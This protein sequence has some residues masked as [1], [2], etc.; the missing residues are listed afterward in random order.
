MHMYEG[1]VE[2]PY[3]GTM[4]C[5]PCR[6]SRQVNWG[7]PSPVRKKNCTTGEMAQQ[8]GVTSSMSGWRTQ[9]KCPFTARRRCTRVPGYSTARYNIPNTILVSSWSGTVGTLSA[10]TALSVIKTS[11]PGVPGFPGR[12]SRNSEAP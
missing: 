5:G 8:N 4:I 7:F 10:N 12:F 1:S 2:S 9:H 11:L 3:P 6:F